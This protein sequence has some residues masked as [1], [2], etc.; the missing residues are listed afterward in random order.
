[1]PK[2]LL[3]N[4][5]G[6]LANRVSRSSI[7]SAY[8]DHR[9][10]SQLA[11]ERKR[12][13]REKPS[14]RAKG[15]GRRFDVLIRGRWRLRATLVR[16]FVI[17]SPRAGIEWKNQAG[18]PY[19]RERGGASHRYLALIM[20]PWKF[21]CVAII[22]PPT[23]NYSTMRVFW[24]PVEDQRAKGGWTSNFPWNINGSV[25]KGAIHLPRFRVLISYPRF[26]RPS[27]RGKILVMQF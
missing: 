20:H 6:D 27:M 21:K 19:S 4:W 11:S 12:C 9:R 26:E 10:R 7:P 1:M 15:R 24:R 22:G 25:S 3:S 13:Q 8:R 5:I 18:V 16:R 14:R 23:V 17:N 2:W